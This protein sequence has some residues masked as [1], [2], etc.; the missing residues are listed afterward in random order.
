MSRAYVNK[1]SD[2]PKFLR[3]LALEVICNIPDDAFLTYTDGSRN[4]HPRSGNGIYIKSQ[5]IPD[6]KLRNSDGCSIFRSELI[7]IDKGLKEAL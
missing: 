3:Q 7:A 1:T 6:T 5:T 2:P 4:K